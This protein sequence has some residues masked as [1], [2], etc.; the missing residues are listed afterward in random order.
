[1]VLAKACTAFDLRTECEPMNAIL[2]WPFH[3]IGR[4]CTGEGLVGRPGAD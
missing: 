1:M 3:D 2:A 4:F